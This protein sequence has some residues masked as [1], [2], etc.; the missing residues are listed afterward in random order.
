MDYLLDRVKRLQDRIETHKS[1]QAA[2]AA[3]ASI[4]KTEI[5]VEAQPAKKTT[6]VLPASPIRNASPVRS[7]A[8]TTTSRS[9]R[10]SLGQPD[11]PPLETLLQTLALSIPV[12][13]ASPHDQVTA[14]A[15]A[16]SERSAKADDVA[17]NAQENFETSAIAHLEDAKLAIQLLRDSVMAESPFGEVK[18][19][20]AEIE[21][22]IEVLAQEVDKVKETLER[23]DGRKGDGKSERR[24]ELLRRWGP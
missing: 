9:N 18:L 20:D 5:A 17:R 6:P 1:H 4:A 7:R 23:M 15:R 12:D 13:P 22:S 11:E 21:S 3:V 2:S 19:V 10:H 14:L 24:D 16:L 8:T